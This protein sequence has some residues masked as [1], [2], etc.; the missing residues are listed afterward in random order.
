MSIPSF[1]KMS[2]SNFDCFV[3]FQYGNIPHKHRVNSCFQEI[4]PW[5]GRALSETD[6]LKFPY[7]Y[8]TSGSYFYLTMKSYLVLNEKYCKIVMQVCGHTFFTSQ[9]AIGPFFPLFF[10]LLFLPFFTPFF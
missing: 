6:P 4:I 1:W 8:C 5:E 3:Y 9:S 10:R 7:N 2:E